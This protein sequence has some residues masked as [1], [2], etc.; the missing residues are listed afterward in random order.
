MKFKI[1]FSRFV[2]L[3]ALSLVL[4]TYNGY[5]Q[6]TIGDAGPPAEGALLQLKQNYS[7]VNDNMTNSQKGFLFPRVKLE[8]LRSLSPL[9]DS[10]TEQEKQA[11]IGML[12]FNTHVEPSLNLGLGIYMWNGSQWVLSSD[13]T[14]DA[15]FDAISPDNI[16]VNGAY[17]KGEPLNKIIH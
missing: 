4:F 9:V 5:A 10:A 11:S 15:L 1:Y 3:L 17:F 6:V 16:T 2:S 8:A 13:A 7:I 12:V 14:G